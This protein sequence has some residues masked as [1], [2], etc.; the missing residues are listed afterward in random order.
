M[1]LLITLLLSTSIQNYHV[2]ETIPISNN[3]TSSDSTHSDWIQELEEHEPIE[4]VSD[5]DFVDQGW[6]GN[7]SESNPFIIEG[8]EIRGRTFCILIRNK[9]N[10][11]GM[12]VIHRKLA[13][14][15]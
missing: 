3:M 8:L 7:G 1:G 10:I 2:T 9:F 6:P 12:S 13:G 15:I 5:A 11:H 14:P 4:I